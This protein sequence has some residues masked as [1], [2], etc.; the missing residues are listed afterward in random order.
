MNFIAMIILATLLVSY[1]LNLLA[2]Q[3]NIKNLRDD[4]PP[5]FKDFYDA[6]KYRKAQA[7]LKTNTQFSR[8]AATF[9]LAVLLCFWFG[10]GFPLLDQWTRSPGYGPIITGLMYMGVLILLRALL[11]LPFSIYDTFVIEEKFGFNQTTIKTYIIDLV[12]SALLASLL[13]TPLIAGILWFFLYTGENAWLFCWIAVTVFMLFIQFVMPTWIMPL[14]NKFTPIEEGP[15]KQAIMD[16][17]ASIH[18]PLKNI[19]IMDGSKRSS[20]SNA[21]FTGFGNNK[22]I[23]LFDTLVEQHSIP[24]LVA[25]LAHEMGHYKK[26]HIQQMLVFAIIQVGILFYLLSFFLSYQGLFD[27]FHMDKPSVHA[28]LIFFSLLF[29]PIDFFIGIILQALSRRN[30]YAADRF[31]VKTTGT[32]QQLK[33]ALKKLSVKNLANLHPHPLYVVLN[34]SHPPMMARL[35]AIDTFRRADLNL[36]NRKKSQ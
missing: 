5:A 13:G 9:H 2:D 32:A 18:F 30:E 22:R 28:G 11:T 10:N 3:L 29:T 31:A 16:Y 20:K 1:F 21:F 34:Y 7:Y 12:K 8:I 19:F 35:A 17:A 25:I 4:I 33:N 36:Q 24:E 14:F 6:E 27:A 26:R 15:L 23:V